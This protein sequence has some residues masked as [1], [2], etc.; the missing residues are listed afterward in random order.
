MK[1]NEELAVEFWKFLRKKGLTRKFKKNVKYAI[2]HSHYGD[3]FERTLSTNCADAVNRGFT[4]YATSE[5]QQFWEKIH[6]EWKNYVGEF[7]E[8][9]IVCGYPVRFNETD[10]I[11][12]VGCNTI[13][14]KEVKVV[15]SRIV[16]IEKGLKK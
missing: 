15:H 3:G 5:G 9:I 14:W 13:S 1:T 11:I 16:K 8:T 6:I 2:E 7:D 10:E 4:W 12:S